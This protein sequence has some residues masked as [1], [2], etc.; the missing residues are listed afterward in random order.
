[1]RSTIC[2]RER[3][4]PE[5][6]LH[7]GP[8]AQLEAEDRSH[9][10]D[11]YDSSRSVGEGGYRGPLALK[12]HQKAGSIVDAEN[13]L[14]AAFNTDVSSKLAEWRSSK[15]IGADP[16]NAYRD[17][18]YGEQIAKERASRR[19]ALGIKGGGSYA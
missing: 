15:G 9:D 3:R 11:S 1:M 4:V 12:K 14:K 6:R 5:Y 16:L 8:I 17:S 7:G 18:G 19:E 10:P 2:G 13:V